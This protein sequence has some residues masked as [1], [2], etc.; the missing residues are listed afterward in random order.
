MRAVASR[1]DCDRGLEVF[2]AEAADSCNMTFV[3]I[4]EL[5]L[6]Q[7]ASSVWATFDRARV[8]EQWRCIASVPRPAACE[9]QVQAWCERAA[10]CG[11]VNSTTG[12]AV[13]TTVASS[14]TTAIAPNTAPASANILPIAVGTVA[15]VVVVAVIVAV[16]VV[17]YRRKTK[18]SRNAVQFEVL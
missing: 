2:V 11:N 1:G 3:V 7:N 12:T 4:T 5:N 9:N 18:S 8:C 15:G 10:C 14:D 13:A 16:A 17:C 6:A